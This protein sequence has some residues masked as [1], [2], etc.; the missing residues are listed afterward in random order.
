MWPYGRSVRSGCVVWPYGRSNQVDGGVD[1]P[2]VVGEAVVLPAGAP[3]VV[4]LQL[5]DHVCGGR[6]I[7]VGAELAALDA[8]GEE[9][10][11]QLAVGFDPIAPSGLKAGELERGVI[12]EQS[13]QQGMGATEPNGSPEH[14]FERL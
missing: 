13:G 12:A 3:G 1:D 5:A 6:G 14:P 11:D 4:R 10:R 2:G 7:E 9:S 8:A